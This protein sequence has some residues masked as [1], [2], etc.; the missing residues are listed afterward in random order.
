MFIKECMTKSPYTVSVDTPLLTDREL[1]SEHDIRH[2]PVLDGKKFVGILSDRNLKQALASPGGERFLVADAM[3]PDAFAVSPETELATVVEEMAKEK[4]GS[5]VIQ[6]Q[7]G[8]VVGVFTTVDAC[9]LLPSCLGT[10]RLIE[11][12]GVTA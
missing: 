2:L 6:E 9:R 10:R 1:L 11:I 5:A 4:Y 12:L 7:D 8:I 3:M